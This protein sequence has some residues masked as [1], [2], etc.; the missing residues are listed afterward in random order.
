M[1]S[2]DCLS[3]SRSRELATEYR[4]LVLV[5]GGELVLSIAN[6]VGNLTL[7]GAAA[8]ISRGI[9]SLGLIGSSAAL[10]YFGYRT[11]RAMALGSPW[12]W[13]IGMFVP[14]VNVVT[15]LALSSRA[16]RLCRAAGIP[17]GLL[18]PQIPAEATDQRQDGGRTRG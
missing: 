4:N 18:G 11:A 16:T 17:V 7:H 2:A 14:C 15:L 9:V 3:A 12:A 13:A 6:V 10:V 5:F 8:E 1:E